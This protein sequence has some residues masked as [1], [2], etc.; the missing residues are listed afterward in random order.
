M[1]EDLAEIYAHYRLFDPTLP[2]RFEARLDDQIERLKVFPES[3]AIIFE[4]Y[5]RVLVKRFP[6]IAVYR[7]ADLRVDV[8]A[9]V[10]TSRDPSRIRSMVTERAD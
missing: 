7:L 5:R 3:G 6:Y 1:V 2:E 8:L 4:V 9:V 10:N